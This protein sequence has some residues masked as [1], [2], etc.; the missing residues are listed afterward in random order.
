VSTTTAT[1]EAAAA[2]YERAANQLELV[3]RHLRTT[4]HHFREG[5]VPRACAHAWAAFGDL[6]RATAA[7]EGLAM[8]HASKSVP[9]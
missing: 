9:E 4:A 6:R 7:I 5:D 3:A 1:R 2:E 8:M